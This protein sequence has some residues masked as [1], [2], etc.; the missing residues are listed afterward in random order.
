M[1]NYGKATLSLPHEE[2]VSMKA[3]MNEKYSPEETL[4]ITNYM[5]PS[6]YLSFG[7]TDFYGKPSGLKI[8]YYKKPTNKPIL[9]PKPTQES[10]KIVYD[11]KYEDLK[12]RSLWPD[13]ARK[14]TSQNIG[15]L[16]PLDNSFEQGFTINEAR[17]FP[18]EI[19]D[20]FRLNYLDK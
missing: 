12:M 20:K 6:S 14:D 7:D 5:E 15:T 10:S 17:Q 18:Q 9:L 2:V 19:R 13:I 8:P 4:K 16:H 11:P 1:Y 3:A